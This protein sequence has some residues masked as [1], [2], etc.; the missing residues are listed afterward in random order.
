MWTHHTAPPAAASAAPPTASGRT[1]DEWCSGGAVAGDCARAVSSARA[2]PGPVDE[3]G[4]LVDGDVE[5]AA[6]AAAA[7]GAA[8]ARATAPAAPGSELAPPAP[9]WT[10]FATVETPFWTRSSKSPSSCGAL[11]G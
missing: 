6:F 10:T 3:L 11:A 9:L 7:A 8:M 5:L 1:S 2:F 4:E